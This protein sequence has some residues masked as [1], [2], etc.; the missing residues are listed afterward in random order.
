MARLQTSPP[1]DISHMVSLGCHGGRGAKGIFW[2]EP[3][4]AAI[5]G[6]G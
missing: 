3:K 1:E 6:K 5:Q 2:V 4:D